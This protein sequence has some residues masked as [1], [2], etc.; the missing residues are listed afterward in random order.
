MINNDDGAEQWVRTRQGERRR[1]RT[2]RRLR[3]EEGEGGG[4]GVGGEGYEEEEGGEKDLGSTT[5]RGFDFLLPPVP[6]LPTPA[7]AAH[8]TSPHPQPLRAFKSPALVV[9]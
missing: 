5:A 6:L 4:G 1:W 8:L 9:F 2:R 3:A 7:A